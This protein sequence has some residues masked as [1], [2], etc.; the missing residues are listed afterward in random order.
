VRGKKKKRKVP[1]VGGEGTWR[2][3]WWAIEIARKETS[4][5]GKKGNIL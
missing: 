4:L 1:P 3:K 2:K 5:L